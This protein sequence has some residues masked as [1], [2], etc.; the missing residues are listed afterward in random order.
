MADENEILGRMA[1]P[2]SF[3]VLVSSVAGIALMLRHSKRVTYR[4]VVSAVLSSAVAC[5]IVFLLLYEYLGERPALLYGVS[6]LSGAGGAST[7]DL[8]LVALRRW[9]AKKG[10]GADDPAG[11]DD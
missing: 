6:C 9:A 2:L 4:D 7:I 10:V 8:L 11:R 5:V 3:T 1:N